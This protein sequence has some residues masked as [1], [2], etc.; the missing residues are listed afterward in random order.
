MDLGQ[1]SEAG[2]NQPASTGIGGL[3]DVLRGGLTP[4]RV[5]LIEGVP[6]SGKT[7]LAMQFLL[8]GIRN[9]ESVL[10]VTLSET[11]DEIRSVATSHG[12]DLSKLTI[13]EL[14][15]TEQGL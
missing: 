8:E 2:A 6:G 15:P 13:R 10:Y 4:H 9:G 11:E 12:W 3:D 5:Y 14:F 1:R 7:T